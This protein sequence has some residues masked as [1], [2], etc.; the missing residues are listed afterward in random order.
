MR[1]ESPDLALV[2][3]VLGEIDRGHA[4]RTEFALDHAAIDHG[5]EAVQGA[6][7]ER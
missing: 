5:L 6:D 4:T 3:Q 7:H 2:S 1:L